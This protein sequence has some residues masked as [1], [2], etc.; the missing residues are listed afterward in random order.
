MLCRDGRSDMGHLRLGVLPKYPKWKTVIGYLNDHDVPAS[1]VADKILDATKEILSSYSSQSSVSYCI[2]F[3]AQLTIASRGNNF[4]KDVN[5]LG[6]RLSKDSSAVDFMARVSRL[7]TTYL[8][9]LTPYNAI[10]PIA[11][12]ALREALTRTIGL[13]SRTLFGSGLEDVQRAL[14]KYSTQKQF[15]NLLHIFFTSFLGRT[16]RYVIDKEI[17]NHLGPGKR[18]QNIRE[19]EEFEAALDIFASQTSRMVDEFSGGWYSKQF[20]QKGYI[21]DIEADH[22]VY[23]ALKKLKSDLDLSGK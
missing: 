8:N 14:K 1:E 5:E 22:F 12:L 10:N 3:I 13:Q 6:I 17:S 20:W 15:S 23:I 4:I 18:F 2:W 21:S 11:G 7:T 16:L 19:I 9:G